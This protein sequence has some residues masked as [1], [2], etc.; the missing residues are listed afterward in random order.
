MRRESGFTLI[1]LMAA[2]TIMTIGLFAIIHMTVISTRGA[3]YARDQDGA[4]LILQAVSEELRVRAM[5]WTEKNSFS[6][7]FPYITLATPTPG[8]DLQM[9]DLK[10]LTELEGRTISSSPAFANARSINIFGNS[11]A[12]GDDGIRDSGAIYRV[13]AAAHL[14]SVRRGELP[15]PDLVRVV[16]FVVFDNKDHGRQDYNWGSIPQD[17]NFWLRQSVSGEVL[18]RRNRRQ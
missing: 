14:Q 12:D 4:T 17:C 1:E 16:L 11:L 8:A 13:F 3:S 5:D 2:M 10:A 18:L 7:V 9:A 6:T 15:N